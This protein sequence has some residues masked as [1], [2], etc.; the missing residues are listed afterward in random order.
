MLRPAPESER[1]GLTIAGIFSIL[2]GFS[3]GYALVT[4]DKTGML[5]SIGGAVLNLAYIV[6]VGLKHSR[7]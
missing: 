7:N 1:L 5:L 2:C 6:W 4:K 3:S